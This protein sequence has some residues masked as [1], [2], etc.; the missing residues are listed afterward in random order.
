MEDV[1]GAPT[2]RSPSDDGAQRHARV[3]EIRSAVKVP[4][5]VMVRL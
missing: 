4:L 3:D 1:Q 2:R 5:G